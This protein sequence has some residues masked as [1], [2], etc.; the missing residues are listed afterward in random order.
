VVLLILALLLLTALVIADRLAA[1]VA[2]G[3]VADQVQEREGL[4]QRPEVEVRGFPFLTQA[5]RGRYDEVDLTLTGVERSGVRVQSVE[6]TLYGVQVP[7]GSALSGQVGEIPVQ[8]AQG[9]ARLTFAD[10]ERAAGGGLELSRQGTALGMRGPVEVLGRTL[11]VT[12]RARLSLEPGGLRVQ[13]EDLQVA[14]MEEEPPAPLGQAVLEQ[15]SFLAPLPALPF[16][17][18]LTDVAVG[19][20]VVVVSGRARNLVLG[21]GL[22]GSALLSSDVVGST[23]VGSFGPGRHPASAATVE[24]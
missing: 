3:V 10:L 6:A 17:L 19:E 18:E 20:E 8:R 24:G 4:R 23:A 13:A 15:L 2:S 1:G 14:G 11:T 16:A 22:L 12:A 5:L 7:L 9:S 21:S